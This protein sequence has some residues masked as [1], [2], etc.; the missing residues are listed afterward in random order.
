LPTD[1]EN[2]RMWRT[3]II[4]SLL[5]DRGHRVTWWTSSFYH[6]LKR[7]RVRKDEVIVLSSR[8]RLI[9]LHAPAYS[10]NISIA[11][12][13]NH[14]MIGRKFVKFAK[15]EKAP[16]IILCS[17]P[18]IELSLA[19]TRYGVKQ[20]V[21]VVLDVRDLW[22]DIFLDFTPQKLRWLVKFLLFPYFWAARSAFRNAT[23][24]LGITDPIMRWGLE[25]ASRPQ[26]PFDRDF[27]FGYPSKKVDATEV[28]RS[29]NFWAK[30]GID[31]QKKAFVCCFFGTLGR[32][33]DLDTVIHAARRLLDQKSPFIFVLCGDGDNSE[34]YRNLA[35]GC[36]N[37]IFPGWVNQ[38]DITVLMKRSS[39]G[40]TP[41]YSKMD[42]SMS[43]P[44]KS[45]E[46]LSAGLPVISSLKGVLQ[47][48]LSVHQC[49]IT[50]ENGN[51]DMLISILT[52]L[53]DNPGELKVMSEHARR[54]YEQ[55]F[56][57]D[58]VYNKMV[59]HLSLI[60]DNFGYRPNIS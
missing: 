45:I 23:A 13:I 59:D 29:V 11:R 51:S 48:L 54:L 18:T 6:A 5:V 20:R 56:A 21:P 4:A 31:H 33:L 57:A 22:P 47:E 30:H 60:R 14:C 28:S 8:Y 55:R 41:Y 32:Q 7:Q 36:D 40:L 35:K 16:D 24:V 38:A 15:R 1:G 9:L 42:F 37:I 52:N 3:G 43:I 26:S 50:Y 39:V 2:V 46:Y 44:N 34:Y 12:L 49:G 25:K 53:Y 17:F 19:A 27:P 58:E 10:R